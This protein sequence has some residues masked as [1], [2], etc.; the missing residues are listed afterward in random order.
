MAGGEDVV[1]I[2]GRPAFHDLQLVCDGDLAYLGGSWTRSAGSAV[3]ATLNRTR[4]IITHIIIT[5][6][7]KNLLVKCV[8]LAVGGDVDSGLGSIES[9]RPPSRNNV[10]V[11]SLHFANC[12]GFLVLP[13]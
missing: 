10:P 12:S 9:D 11:P 3:S 4:V 6:F 8:R 5:H 1:R 7:F 13:W 2:L